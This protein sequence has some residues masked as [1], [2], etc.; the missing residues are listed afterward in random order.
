LPPDIKKKYFALGV[1]KHQRGAQRRAEA[2]RQTERGPRVEPAALTGPGWSSRWD[3]GPLLVPSTDGSL[4]P[5]SE[6]L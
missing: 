5:G 3:G 4:G 2:Q 1:V 6:L